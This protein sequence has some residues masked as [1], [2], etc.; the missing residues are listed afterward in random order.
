MEFVPGKTGF[1]HSLESR[2]SNLESC[3]CSICFGGGCICRLSTF[4]KVLHRATMEKQLVL[5]FYEVI[6][7]EDSLT[8]FVVMFSLSCELRIENILS[9]QIFMYLIF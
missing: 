9:L 2:S 8:L 7:E 6:S 4:I 5:M 3:L 1:G